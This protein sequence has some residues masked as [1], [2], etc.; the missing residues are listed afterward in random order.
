MAF[1]PIEYSM[2][3]SVTYT[4]DGTTKD[5]I[6]PFP[7]LY[8]DDVH[9]V[10]NGTE[11]T[12]YPVIS[13][14][15]PPS[16]FDGHWYADNLIRLV[17][18]PR[19]DAVV[20][21]YRETNRATAE[22]QFDNSAILT[23]EDLNLAVTQLLYIVQ[24]SYDNFI[25]MYHELVV[26]RDSALQAAD[27]AEAA[28]ENLDSKVEYIQNYVQDLPIVKAS[29]S[30]VEAADRDGFFWVPRETSTEPFDQSEADIIRD[31]ISNLAENLESTHKR[32]EN[33]HGVTIGIGAGEAV[34]RGREVADLVALG[35]NAAHNVTKARNCVAIGEGAL[36]NNGGARHNI[37]IGTEALFSVDGWKDADGNYDS[38]GN[39]FEGTRNVAVGGNAGHFITTGNRN[40]ML[41]RDAGHALTSATKN[42]AIGNGVMLGDAPNCLTENT[43][44]LQTPLVGNS[45]VAIGTSAATYLNGS[46]AVAIGE[47]ALQ[48]AK[49]VT[50]VI[51]I[52][53]DAGKI[54]DSNISPFGTE[55]TVVS[56][57]GTYAQNGSTEIKVTT[58]SNH[59]L[60]AG[61]YVRLR[62]TDGLLGDISAYDDMWF[63][64]KSVASSTVLP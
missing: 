64:V 13:G 48:N 6:V 59:G 29:L 52:G 43:V 31:E 50:G 36:Y 44:I 61:W 53:I 32:W 55:Q 25:N 63:V 7:Y 24:E 15:N 51:A 12:I 14:D 16:P 60:S 18:A 62:F 42:V 11:K 34:D 21:I 41:G 20:K 57:S 2:Y 9:V 26:A 38:S 54:L 37:A 4:G 35:T 1:T 27:R 23:E 40:I 22:V 56:I 17:E 3:S 10:I 45:N 49:G 30:E 39:H 5:F 8:L 28:V 47:N 19:Q 33:L 46:G 58:A